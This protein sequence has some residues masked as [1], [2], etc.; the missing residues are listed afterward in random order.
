MTVIHNSFSPDYATQL[1]SN[2]YIEGSLSDK[3]PLVIGFVGNLLGYK[4]I[5]D[6][7]YAV[8]IAKEHGVDI[9]L[10]IVGASVR[11]A[12]AS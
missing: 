8:H 9:C 10:R 3:R 4:G 2:T 7:L 12:R 5:I 11:P 6:P 1:K